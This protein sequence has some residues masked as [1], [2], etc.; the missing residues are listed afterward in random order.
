MTTITV[1]DVKSAL[2]YDP[3]T[4]VFTWKVRRGQR[5]K[6][7]A[8][9]GCSHRG[10]VRIALYGKSYMAHVLAFFY[11]TGDWPLHEIDHKDG[12]KAN[13]RWANLR[14][15]TRAQNMRNRSAYKNN[16]LGLKGIS[17]HARGRYQVTIYAD[18][19][20][21]YMG[22]YVSLDEAV[23]VRDRALKDVHADFARTA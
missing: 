17:M 2:N 19:R 16:K 23:K 11:M 18:K 5:G 8:S 6:V 12:D 7:G 4:G 13:N 3:E 21:I 9:A 14:E 10:Y 1:D 15:A 22:L 20:P